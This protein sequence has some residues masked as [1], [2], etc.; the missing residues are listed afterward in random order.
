MFVGPLS[1]TKSATVYKVDGFKNETNAE[2]PKIRVLGQ[3]PTKL[4]AKGLK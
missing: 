4:A 1:G 2:V 3:A